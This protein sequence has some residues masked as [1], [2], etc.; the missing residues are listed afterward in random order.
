LSGPSLANRLAD[1]VGV[2]DVNFDRGCATPSKA[3]PRHAHDPRN[4][5]PFPEP[6]LAVDRIG[7]LLLPN[8]RQF[9][10]RWT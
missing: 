3:N 6:D 4:V 8:Y 7:N 1:P 5:Q 9:L 2:R 10:E